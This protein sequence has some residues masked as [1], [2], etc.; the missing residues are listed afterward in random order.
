MKS[1]TEDKALIFN[2][3]QSP[4][5]GAELPVRFTFPFYY[6][7]HPLCVI[8]AGELQQIIEKQGDWSNSF[9]TNAEDDSDKS[10]KM[11]GVLVVQDTSGK[12]GYL[13]AYSGKLKGAT[14]H[15]V[16]FVY[17][18][19]RDDNFYARGMRVIENLG[20]QIIEAENLP[21]MSMAQSNLERVKR[22]AEEE[23]ELFR[24]D[25]RIARAERKKQR[26]ALH[27]MHDA[28]TLM[29]KLANESRHQRYL[30]KSLEAD[31]ERKISKAQEEFDV[32]KN[33]L[34]QLIKKRSAFSADL[35]KQLFDKYTFL[36]SAGESK[37]LTEIFSDVGLPPSGAGDCAAPKLLQYAFANKL[38]PIAM[39]EFWWGPSPKTTI[40]HHKKYYP[41]C[42]SKCKP[43]LN[44]MLKGMKLDPNPMLM[45]HG[46]NKKLET[47]YEDDHILIVNKPSGLLSVPGK[48]ITES[49][50]ARI[51]MKYGENSPVLVHRLDMDTS[52]LL[53]LAKSTKVHKR[54]QA[55]FLKRTVKK[56]YVALLEGECA[57]T[58]G[59]I[60]LP[61]RVDVADRPNQ[62]VCF[63]HGKPSITRFEVTE[64][65]SGRT[66]INFYPQTGRTHQLRVHAAHPLGLKCPI[67]GDILYGTDDKRMYLHAEFL[68]FK[69]PHTRQTVSFEAKAEF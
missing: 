1:I 50:A 46:Q 41:A 29:E 67:V 48:E 47:I 36:N 66:R 54:L 43:I 26:Q 51:K 65:K 68:E 62:M 55:Q 69:H 37:S 24:A 33:A 45:E 42:S 44:F 28:E 16:P 21:A 14:D 49:V 40:R 32:F 9:A 52:G 22:S 56:R 10:G 63:T 61:L 35:Q 15:F 8:A 3:F 5:D 30:L 57:Q 58:E 25:M 4:I 27:K 13:A 18:L 7:P 23:I 20:H 59:L 17:N 34:N 2:S 60:D 19:P 6:Q 64:I 12:L 38:K 39:A 31:W 11:F 53:L